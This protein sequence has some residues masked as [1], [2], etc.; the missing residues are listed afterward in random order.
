[1]E[2]VVVIHPENEHYT[3]KLAELYVTQGGKQNLKHAIK[4]YSHVISR[5]PKNVRAL[6]GLYR[7]LVSMG[8]NIDTELAELKEVICLINTAL[9]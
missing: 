1:M 8:D 2:E 6:W 4:Y 7:V 3:I 5:S 9:L